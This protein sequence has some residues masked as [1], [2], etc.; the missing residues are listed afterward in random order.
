MYELRLP[1]S[2]ELHDLLVQ[3]NVELSHLGNSF[4]ACPSPD[5]FG[6]EILQVKTWSLIK[7]NVIITTIIEFRA[8]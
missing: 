2:K 4:L 8:E 7:L 6:S 3:F 5:G 1:Y